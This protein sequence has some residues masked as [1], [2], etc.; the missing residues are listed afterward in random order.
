M[1]TPVIDS[2]GL[3]IFGESEWLEKRHKTMRKRRFWRKLH[4]SFDLVS[5]ESVCSDLTTDDVDDP[6]ALPDLLHQVDGAVDLFLA[7]GAYDGE[8]TS[9]LL[10]ARFGP[11]I[12]VTISPPE[13]AILSPNAAHN[14]TARDCHIADIATHGRMVWQKATGQINAAGAKPSWAAGKPSLGLKSRRATSEV[15]KQKPRSASG[16]STG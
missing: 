10:A 15:R 6:T 13:N 4:L 12:E 14:P 16:F 9:D 11:M 5:G 7:D 3:K 8:P 2:T 1:A